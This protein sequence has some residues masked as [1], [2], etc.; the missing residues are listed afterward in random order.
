VV[1]EAK[2]AG[3]VNEDDRFV[4]IDV[5]AVFARP[6]R[7]KVK[8][9]AWRRGTPDGDNILKAVAD[10]LQKARVIKNDTQV[11]DW[12]VRCVYGAEGEDAHLEVFVY[13]A[14]EVTCVV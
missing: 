5:I 13:R 7:H 11:V 1:I 2:R 3:W 12:R 6:K 9:R 10:G 4:C 14:G 8:E